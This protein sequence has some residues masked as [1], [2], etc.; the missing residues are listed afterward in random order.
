MKG[1]AAGDRLLGQGGAD[2]LQGG[3]GAEADEFVFTARHGRDTIADFTS[4]SDLINLG[5][6]AAAGFRD[7][8]ISGQGGGTLITTGSGRIFL[9]DLLPGQLDADDFL[10]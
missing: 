10:F 3:D 1:G 8:G 2:S 7:L 9:E 6:T 5:G 4:G